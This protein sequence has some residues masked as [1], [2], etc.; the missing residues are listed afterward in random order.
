MSIEMSVDIPST[1]RCNTDELVSVTQDLAKVV[2]EICT[3]IKLLKEERKDAVGDVKNA[4]NLVIAN[5]VWIL[6]QLI[7]TY[8]RETLSLELDKPE[9]DGASNASNAV[10]IVP[11]YFSDLGS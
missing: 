10:T 9:L 8:W 2:S 4:Y 6:Q 5:K 1:I 7:G 11:T 3:Q